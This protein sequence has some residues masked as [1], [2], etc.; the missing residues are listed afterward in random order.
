VGEG[1]DGGRSEVHA[2]GQDS[3]PDGEISSSRSSSVGLSTV[4]G[5]GGRAF[6]HATESEVSLRLGHQL[7]YG[8]HDREPK[9]GRH[10][11]I[12]H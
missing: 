2:T 8:R 9:A 12:S 3:G 4:R 1:W 7:R 5:L 11:A 6:C 10:D